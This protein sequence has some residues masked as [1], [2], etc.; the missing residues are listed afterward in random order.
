MAYYFMERKESLRRL[1]VCRKPKR[2]E[3]NKIY[4]SSI[5]ILREK[6]VELG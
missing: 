5:I 2:M 6:I 1:Y 4:N 3:T